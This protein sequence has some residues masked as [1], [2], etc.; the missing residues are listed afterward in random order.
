MLTTMTLG[1]KIRKYRKLKGMT[2][3]ELGLAAGFSPAT[4]D[5]RIRKYERNEVAPKDGIRKK[6]AK[7]LGVD[8]PAISDI[9][10]ATDE[11][12]MQ[13]LFLLEE[14]YGMGI[15][16]RD[17]KTVLIFDDANDSIRTLNNYMN[18]WYAQRKELLSNPYSVTDDRIRDYEV[19]K[20]RLSSC[21]VPD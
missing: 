20:S 18:L 12:V 3:K 4:A 7:A 9:D 10:V 8:L 2:Q 5:S 19:W 6:L 13:V 21:T 14:K 15:D 16:K 1:E 17:G 11:D